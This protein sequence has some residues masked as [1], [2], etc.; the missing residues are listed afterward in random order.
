MVS[1]IPLLIVA[2]AFTTGISLAFRTS[3]P[4]ADF[5]LGLAGVSLLLGAVSAR[6]ACSSPGSFRLR[7]GVGCVLLSLLCTGM[8]AG[9]LAL[10]PPR[11]LAS[12]PRVEPLLGC[13]FGIRLEGTVRG[14]SR[15]REDGIVFDLEVDRL[16]GIEVREEPRRVRLMLRGSGLDPRQQPTL[17]PGDRL[18]LSASIR[19]LRDRGQP[20]AAVHADQLRRAGVALRG[21]VKTPLLVRRLAGTD[22]D[23]LR[24]IARLRGRLLDA[25][26]ASTEPWRSVGREI[27]SALVVGERSRLDPVQRQQLQQAGTSHLLAISGMHVGLIVWLLLRVVRVAGA[28]PWVPLGTILL[29]LP[30]YVALT[31]MR[32]SAVRA[33]LMAAAWVVGRLLTR[34]STPLNALGLACMAAL[35][36]RP[37]AILELGFQL[38]FLAAA[39][40]LLFT[41]RLESALRGPRWLRRGIAASLAST[42]AVAPVL[43]A[44]AHWLAPIGIVANLAAVPLAGIAVTAGWSAV[45][46]ELS[47][48]GTGR[49]PAWAALQ[50]VEALVQSSGLLGRIPGGNWATPGPSAGVL[51]IYYLL[52]GGLAFSWAPR[53]QRLLLLALVAAG[54]F[55]LAGAPGAEPGEA[56]EV[57]VLD[58]GQGDAILVRAPDGATLLVDAGGL[59]R[60]SF[61]IGARIVAPSL[62]ALGVR[63]LDLVL[64]T[65]GHRDHLGGLPS[66]L[67]RIPAQ[68]VWLPRSLRRS[69]H[70]DV[71]AILRTCEERSVPVRWVH[72]GWRRRWGKLTL[73]VLHPGA[74]G[75]GRS[76]PNRDSLVLRLTYGERCFLLVGDAG[77][78]VEE[79]LAALGEPGRCDVLKVGHH[80]SKGATS[81]AFLARVGPSLAAIS[82]GRGNPWGH[83]HSEVL[84]RLRAQGTRTL[85]T[86]WHGTIRF[87]TN[88][89]WVRWA[90]TDFGES[91]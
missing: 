90:V 48:P 10:H 22:R 44:K 75:P 35:L 65:H 88:G 81:K 24:P 56:L 14:F 37:A 5:C 52:L 59:A 71:A 54:A 72:R 80:G 73:E 32:P 28:P 63:R 85:R 12:D 17:L 62:W 36:F 23:P 19:R 2:G 4:Q 13:G 6:G 29:F 21:T 42:L 8:A 33:G 58:V 16:E 38:S 45:F 76:D 87:E 20:G 3:T 47:L 55:V 57:H 9:R 51:S 77:E 74:G 1:S 46:L 70:A 30:L 27:L 39:S 91:P 69:T 89:R 60:S 79:L 53:V 15:R 68:E 18:A 82:S 61:D 25:L 40:I 86:D 50:A 26:R 43:A 83:P 11:G 64:G 78:P 7:L 67:E 31:G 49:W 41:P 66:V 34:G 84:S